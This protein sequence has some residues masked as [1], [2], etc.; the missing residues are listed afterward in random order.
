MIFDRLKQGFNQLKKTFQSTRSIL[1]GKL[2]ALFG[3][4]LD[5]DSLEEMEH[6][7]FEA[8][9]GVETAKVLTAKVKQR[10]KSGMDAA[11]LLEATKKDVLE[12]LDIPTTQPSSTT[13]WII[14]IVGV[15]GSG[16][17]TSVAKL[18]H[19][20]HQE[21][22]KVLLGAA[23]TFRAA[24]IDQLESWANKIGVD[25][26][27]GKPQG[28]PAAVCYDTISAAL[29][30]KADV[31]LIDTAG[32]LQNKEHLMKELEKIHRICDKLAPGSPHETLLTLDAT[33]G[34][35]G[36]NQAQQF[37]QVTPLTGLILTKMDGSA[38]GGVVVPIQKA[39]AIPVKYIGLGETV[40]DLQPFN[41]TAFV[42]A[43]FE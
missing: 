7:F 24:A 17:T 5:E 9:L 35:N 27:K 23:D 12:L 3:K 34:Q 6:L 39:M 33:T 10:S 18:A 19:H 42:T 15:N 37:H 43:L 22:K 16:K 14:L 21:G 2:R 4:P 41:P 20:F 8:D 28:D 30:R 40:G 26:V 31:V 32:R 36:L 11:S 25:I 38:K 1:G 13:P 29:S